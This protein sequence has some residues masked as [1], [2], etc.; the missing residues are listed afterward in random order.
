MAGSS[1]TIGL[2]EP[3]YRGDQSLEQSLQRR[4]S[5]RRFLEVPLSLGEIGQLAWAAQGVTH[6]EGLRTAPSAGALYPLELYLVAGQVTGLEPGVYRYRPAGHGLEQHASGD[7]R[8]AL[9]RAS[10]GQSWMADAA[11]IYVFA[12]V[13][14]RSSGKYGHRARRYVQLEAGHAGQNLFLQA[15]ALGL[16]TVV[17]GA[18]DDDE[19]SSVVGLPAGT[20]PLSIMP[21]G[22]KPLPGNE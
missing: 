5:F 15:E 22:K 10:L 21:V 2:P 17:V 3:D 14:Q 19:V 18:F 8:Q 12:A 4:R 11:A 9:A 13:Y 6:P 7:R 20:R 16:G 1:G